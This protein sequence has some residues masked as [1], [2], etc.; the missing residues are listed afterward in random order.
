MGIKLDHEVAEKV[1]LNV[2]LKPLELYQN[3]TS[4]WKCKC[5]SC[6]KIVFPTYNTI[7]QFGSGCRYCGYKKARLKRLTPQ[8]EAIAVMVKAGLKPLEP[9][10]SSHTK[11]KCECLE[12]GKVVHPRFST[13]NT[14]GG[15]EY[16]AGNKVD[17]EDA[18]AIMLSAHAKPLEAYKNA[19]AKWKSE[20]LKCRR[21]IHPIYDS[22]RRGNGACKYCAKGQYVDPKDAEKLMIKAGLKPLEPYKGAGSKWKCIHK[23]CKKIVYPTYSSIRQ[24]GSGCIHCAGVAKLSDEFT[25]A[26]MIKGNLMPLEPY[27]TS[28]A[29]WKCKCMKCHKTVYP[30]FGD[31]QNGGIGCKYCAKGQYVD[32]KDAEKLMIRNGFKPLEPYAGG[33]IKWKCIHIKCGKNVQVRYQEIRAGKGGCRTCATSGFQINKKSYIYLITHNSFGAYKVG[34][35]NVPQYKYNDRLF[36]HKKEGWEVVEVWNFQDG[37]HMFE[38]ESEIFKIIRVDLGL[39]P[40]LVKGQMK[41]SGETETVDADSVSLLELKRIIKKVIKGYRQ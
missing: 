10:K 19:R 34:I 21:I 26:V 36:R 38:I 32:P 41:F 28:K 9:F 25:R 12:C 14:G 4:K 11:W 35:A 31:V 1:M 39:P 23:K 24:G 33:H 13:V 29:K 20:C 27:V 16:C 15:C 8:K 40:Y 7:K 5:L 2:G 37:N 30:R 22:V 6:E 3:A 17:S 18:V